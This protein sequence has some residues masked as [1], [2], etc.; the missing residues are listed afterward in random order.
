MK[1]KLKIIASVPLLDAFYRL[2]GGDEAIQ[3]L[4]A[5]SLP[6]MRDE[7]FDSNYRLLMK[8]QRKGIWP[9]GFDCVDWPEMKFRARDGTEVHYPVD[10]IPFS[11]D[12]LFIVCS[13]DPNTIPGRAEDGLLYFAEYP[14]CME[15][16]II[17]LPWQLTK[18]I[19]VR[20]GQHRTRV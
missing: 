10:I 3:S 4:L 8:G 17:W 12:W 14:N 6:D 13:N 19:G 7:W 20:D 18:P 11:P 15:G 16:K 1:S 5:H 2:P 9:S